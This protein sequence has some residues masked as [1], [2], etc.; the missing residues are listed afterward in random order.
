MKAV[1]LLMASSLIMAVNAQG[2]TAKPQLS[3]EEVFVT[4]QKRTESMQD[5]PISMAAFAE[6]QLEKEGINNLADIASK[7][8]GLSMTPFPIN[9]A[10][11]NIY[12][13]G[14]GLGDAQIT[15]DSPVGV[16]LD[17]A[18]IARSA[19]LSLDIADLQRIEVLRGPQGTLYG[20]NSTGG[21][22]NLISK[23]PDVNGLGFHQKLS[24]GNRGQFSTKTSLNL[25]LGDNAAVKLAFLHAEK[26]G[27]IENEGAGR[28]FGDRSVNGFRVDVGWEISSRLQLDYGYDDANIEYV[29]YPYQA[30]TP[31]SPSSDT[32]PGGVISAQLSANAS[33]HYDYSDRRASRMASGVPMQASNVDVEGHTL[34]LVYSLSDESEIRYIGAYRELLDGSYAELLASGTPD[35]R[36]DYGAYRSKDERVYIPPTFPIVSQ[37]QQ[38]HELQW[39]GELRDSRLE[40]IVGLYYF[41]E[42]AEEDNMPRHPL[43]VGVLSEVDAGAATTTTY[44]TNFAGKY[45][46]IRNTAAA[47]FGRLTWTPPLLSEKLRLTL[48]ARVSKDSRE[49]YQFRDNATT[50][51]TETRDNFTGELSGATAPQAI[52]SQSWAESGAGGFRDT[53]LEGIAGYQL[54]ETVNLY[55]KFSQ[56]YKSGGFNTRDP[57]PAEFAAGFDAEKVASWELGIKSDLFDRRL[58]W[59]ADVFVSQYSDMQLSFALPSAPS[60]TRVV[61]TGKAKM[62]GAEMDL[63]FLLNRALMLTL[64]YAYLEAEVQEAI[65]P[66][67]AVDEAGIYTFN[68]IP[69]HA[70]NAALDWTVAETDY[71]RWSANV[72]INYMAQRN[73]TSLREDIPQLYLDAHRLLNARF[74]LYD[75][76]LYGG[77]FSASAWGKNL[78]DTEYAISS[79]KQLVHTDRGVVWGEPRSYG[80]NIE[81]RY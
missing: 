61:N 43:F 16:Y 4:A 69:R 26:D 48:G 18:Y 54:S 37:K 17:G 53:S 50:L 10:T 21:A 72:S 38:S 25:P 60:D 51:E 76:P 77:Y 70:Y 11:L 30:I 24:A 23:R 55:A 62:Q 56:A 3:L 1:R 58:R 40:Y 12:I 15:M 64:N 20:R 79:L 49:A 75:V 74:G 27:F 7:V 41:E 31:Q 34:N 57:D 35:Y 8:P 52:S 66:E 68:A 32:S 29:N 73:G 47:L 6:D 9:N 80:L 59:N 33:R 42:E 78:Q 44:L 45:N 36:V 14:V 13:R 65:N 19:G 67:T 2:V 81:Y 63:I 5:T 71:G 39:L 46:R 22:I 28:D